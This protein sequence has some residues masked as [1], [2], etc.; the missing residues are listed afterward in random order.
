MRFFFSQNFVKIGFKNF[1]L[2]VKRTNLLIIIS[3]ESIHPKSIMSEAFSI[4][5]EKVTF[6]LKA[7]KLYQF[8]NA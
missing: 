8:N 5:K 1:V 3:V 2:F 7:D 6:V 4:T